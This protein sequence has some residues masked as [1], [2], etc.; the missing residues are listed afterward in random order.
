V[1]GYSVFIK[2][3]AA[4]ELD[5]VT[6]RRD[7]ARLVAKVRS[8]GENPRPPGCQKLSG[9]EKYR[10]RVGDYRVVYSIEDDRSRVLVVKVGHR[11]DVYRV[12]EPAFGGDVP[13]G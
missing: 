10:V 6:N 8:L 12:S 2:P 1:A 11:R 13:P 5:A 9:S 4:K 3:S 7:R